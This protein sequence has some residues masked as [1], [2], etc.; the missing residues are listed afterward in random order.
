MKFQN[1]SSQIVTESHLPGILATDPNS[2]LLRPIIRLSPQE[3][4]ERNVDSKGKVK[5]EAG[6]ER[7]NAGRKI[8]EHQPE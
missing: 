8:F 1:F 3:F 6:K 2:R 4:F 7:A 5:T